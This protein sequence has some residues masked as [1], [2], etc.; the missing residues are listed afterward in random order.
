MAVLTAKT[1]AGLWYECGL[2]GCPGTRGMA[3]TAERCAAKALMLVP[4]GRLERD[5]QYPDVFE[6]WAGDEYLGR[7][8]GLRQATYTVERAAKRQ[9][10]ERN[11]RC[12][13]CGEPGERKGH[14]TCQYPQD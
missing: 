12:P 8:R 13:D 5:P 9:H 14:Q 1:T 4:G 7:E 3:H 10:E 6:M 2:E 11:R